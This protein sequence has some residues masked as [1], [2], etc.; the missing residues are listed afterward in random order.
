MNFLVKSILLLA[1]LNQ[2]ISSCS[3]RN[4]SLIISLIN[5]VIEGER[6]WNRMAYSPFERAIH[7]PISSWI[8]AGWSYEIK[9]HIRVLQEIKTTL[10]ETLATLENDSDY[11]PK[12]I[13]SVYAT[14]SKIVACDGKPSH[15]SRNWIAYSCLT[16]GAIAAVLKAKQYLDNTKLFEFESNQQE[17]TAICN[18]LAEKNALQF[19]AVQYQDKSYLKISE[20]DQWHVKEALDH[21]LKN[22]TEIEVKTL[23]VTDLPLYFY[24]EQGDNRIKK[25]LDKSLFDPV[26]N[27]YWKIFKEPVKKSILTCNTDNHAEDLKIILAKVAQEA[28]EQKDYD[29]LFT[30]FELTSRK[31]APNKSI[32]ELQ[33]IH[34]GILHIAETNIAH[35]L[36]RALSGRKVA[37]VSAL[38][39]RA[40]EIDMKMAELISDVAIMIEKQNIVIELVAMMPGVLLTYAGYKIIKNTL[41]ARHKKLVLNPLAQDLRDFEILL[42]QY[43]ETHNL[44]NYFY[45][46]QLYWIAQLES[47]LDLI[48]TEQRSN[49]DHDIKRLKNRNLSVQHQ[50][51]IVTALLRYG[52]PN[53]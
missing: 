43:R 39:A 31:L 14:A 7:R 47:Y 49:F 12:T 30:P 36:G 21:V 28:L 29:S 42:D 40:K 20:N 34:H 2:S 6:Y 52:L 9:E 1:L 35:N 26:K 27:I 3:I 50:L 53:F 11:S 44:D 13:E 22:G 10:A 32:G 38:I 37:L 16:I 15:L 24:N 18:R 33:A 5:Q 45:G 19:D 46:M 25:F 51:S 8:T 41:E 23:Q 17:W 48:K 4:K